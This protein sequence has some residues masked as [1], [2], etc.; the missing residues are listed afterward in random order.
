LRV[1]RVSKAFEALV[2]ARM[3]HPNVTELRARFV[4]GDMLHFPLNLPQH[5]GKS[6]ADTEAEE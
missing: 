1:D 5:D 4:D 3:T 6:V 2:T